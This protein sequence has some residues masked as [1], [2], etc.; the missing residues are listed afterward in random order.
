MR[1]D[2]WEWRQAHLVRAWPV[3]TTVEATAT[4]FAAYKPAT[5]G[6]GATAYRLRLPCARRRGWRCL[7]HTEPLVHTSRERNLVGMEY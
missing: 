6:P 4:A 1:R 7:V 3:P 5:Y 2:R